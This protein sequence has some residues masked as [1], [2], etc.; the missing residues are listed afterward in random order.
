MLQTG[1]EIIA[2]NKCI[3][4]L[5]PSSAQASS[6]AKV[7]AELALISINPAPNLPPPPTNPGKFIFQHFSVNDDQVSIQE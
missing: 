4:D 3:I 2:G 7:R 6:Q 1:F 5:L